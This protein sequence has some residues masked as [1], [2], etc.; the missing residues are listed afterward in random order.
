MAVPRVTRCKRRETRSVDEGKGEAEEEVKGRKK[1][2][3]EYGTK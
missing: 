2:R 3:R 1:G